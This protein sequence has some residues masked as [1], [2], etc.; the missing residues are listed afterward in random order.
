MLIRSLERTEP[1]N[2]GRRAL[3][4]EMGLKPKPNLIHLLDRNSYHESRFNFDGFKLRKGDSHLFSRA[5]R[6]QIA[7]RQSSPER[8]AGYPSSSS[9]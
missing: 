3:H 7:S 8:R 5:L 2:E 9:S 4:N 6:R 1:S